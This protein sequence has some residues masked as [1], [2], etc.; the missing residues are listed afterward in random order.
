MDSGKIGNWD[1]S[2]LI[3]VVQDILTGSGMQNFQQVQT[4]DLIVTGKASFS[5]LVAF[6]KDSSY[7][8]VG[9]T[10]A[11]AFTNAWVNF[12]APYFNASYW[13]DPLGFIH[14]RGRIKTGTV[15]NAAFTLPPGYRPAA[16]V[17]F[18]VLSNSTIGGLHVEAD[19]EVIPVTPSNNA[20][21]SLDGCYFKAA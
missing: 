20:S 12:G 1:T 18:A 8:V 7:T 21:V 16:T 4:R 13:K 5:D 6:T 3:K 15:G 11:P 10:G 19:G 17:G 14:L 9:N 2:T